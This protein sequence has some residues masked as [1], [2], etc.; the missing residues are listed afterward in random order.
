MR[1]SDR[2]EESWIVEFEIQL[3]P[4]LNIWPRQV[5]DFLTLPS[6]LQMGIIISHLIVVRISN[7]M[8]VQYMRVANMVI[9]QI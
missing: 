7:Y 2:V 4:L 1:G 9:I 8:R 5:L 6:P 3:C